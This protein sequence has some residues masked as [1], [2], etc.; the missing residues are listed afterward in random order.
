MSLK[1]LRRPAREA[2]LDT[3][4]FLIKTDGVVSEQETARMNM[5]RRMFEIP[6]D[7]YPAD[8][9]DRS[10]EGA[11]DILKNLPKYARITVFEELER[12][13]MCDE[14]DESEKALMNAIRDVFEI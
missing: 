4:A 12:L 1:E 2:F 11:L 14:Y 13:A 6:E 9:R 7:E 5:Y 10:L 3:A 8:G